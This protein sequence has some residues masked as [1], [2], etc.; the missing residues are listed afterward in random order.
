MV[1][2]CLDRAFGRGYRKFESAIPAGFEA[3]RH[4]K[5]AERLLERGFR[6]GE[7]GESGVI[8]TLLCRRGW[9]LFPAAPVLSKVAYAEDVEEGGTCSGA[10]INSP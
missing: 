5:E 9:H 1:E 7:R 2:V 8:E 4:R 6:V 10:L 3:E